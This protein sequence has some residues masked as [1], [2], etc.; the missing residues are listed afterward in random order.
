MSTKVLILAGGSG[1]RFWPKSTKDKP[2]QF[3]KI[4][5]DKTM[6]QET[7][8]RIRT[9]VNSKDVYVI[10]NANHSN[11]ILDQLK[12][13]KDNLLLE[14][15][16]KNTAAA[17]AFGISKM[18]SNDIV[19]V[20]PSDHYI[21]DEK[22]YIDILKK[23]AEFVSQHDVIV[24][25]GIKPTKPETGYGYI[26]VDKSIFD[27][28]FVPVK[29]FHEKPNLET[30][31]HYIESGNFFW[32]AGIFIFKVSAMKKAFK[33]FLPDMYKLFFESKKDIKEIYKLIESISIDYGIMEKANNIFMIPGNFGWSDVGSWDALYDLLEKDKD[34]NFS[35][36]KQVVFRD[37]K[38]C[39]I[40]AEGKTVAISHLEDIIVVVDGDK[41][42][43]TKRGTTQDVKN[44]KFDS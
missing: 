44:I 11:H 33:E 35:D 6:I 34:G 20:L 26:E 5:S 22:S 42:L 18:N 30:A 1:T 39:G 7:V 17:I 28:D 19:I 2:K 13:E 15:E 43:I 29:R 31:Y 25:I 41:I 16:G 40:F 9:L 32:N 24:T 8:D 36:A 37:A 27:K 23:S 3:L 12:I 10:S 4:T 38:N 14:P 21:H